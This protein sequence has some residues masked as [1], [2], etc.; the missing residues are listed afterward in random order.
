MKYNL[1]SEKRLVRMMRKEAVIIKGEG[2]GVTAM[3][4]ARG[5]TLEQ[6]LGHLKANRKEWVV[7]NNL[8]LAEAVDSYITAQEIYEARV[9]H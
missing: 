3:L 6:L 9:N 7:L 5:V 2:F 4:P 8:P 1:E